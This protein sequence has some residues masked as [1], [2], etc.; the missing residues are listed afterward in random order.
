MHFPRYERIWLIAGISTLFLFLLLFG[1]M[2]VGMGLNPPNHTET[3]D[4]KAVA[5]TPPFDNPG[6]KQIGNNEYE[7]T[8][9]AQI[10]MFSPS[11]ITVPAG[12]K[13]H[14]QVTTPD[15]VHGMQIAGTNVNIMAIPGHITRYTHTFHDPGDYLIVCNEYCGTGHHYMI[16]RFVVQ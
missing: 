10:F 1:I 15:V 2:A 5:A 16:G 4:P 7:L 8:M 9:T 13:V 11:E 3:I 6:L 12:S 14:F